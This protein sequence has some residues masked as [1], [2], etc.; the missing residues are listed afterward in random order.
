MKR[1][2]W[3][4]PMLCL[5]VSCGG[6][7][8][9]TESHSASQPQT[10]EQSQTTIPE[11]SD[12]EVSVPDTSINAEETMKLLKDSPFKNDMNCNEDIG[13]SQ[14]GEVGIDQVRFENETL[15]TIPK[16]ATVYKASEIGLSQ[17]NDNN[18]G[19]LSLF[20]K[21]LVNVPGN[22]V[23]LFEGITYEF[24]SMVDVVGVENLSFLGQE[25][26]V[27]LNTSW[28]T[29]FEA[30]KCKN[31]L[32]S[33]IVFDMKYSPT[34]GGEITAVKEGDS[35]TEVTL[36]VSDEYDL[37]APLYANYKVG[38]CSY[39]EMYY[40]QAN[41]SYVPNPQKNLVYNSPSSA[42][43][44]GVHAVTADPMKKELHITISKKF[45]ASSY[46]TPKVGTMVSFAYTMYENEG[47]HFNDCENTY[48]EHVTLHV[49]GGM[50]FRMMEGKNAYFNHVQVKLKEGS[51]SL[52]TCTADIIHGGGVAGDFKIQNCWLESSHDDAVN[53]K[54][55]YT[56][57]VSINAS[58]REIN[59]SQTQNEL[60]VDFEAG[61]VI[62]IFNPEN[63]GRVD[64][65]TLESVR[66][67]G[68]N[69]ILKLDRRPRNVVV[70]Q[71]CG[72]VT[73]ASH[74]TLDNTLIRNKRNRGILLQGRDSK[75]VNCTF[76]NVMMGS[77]QIL[78]VN[79]QFR[80]AIV[81]ANVQ[82]ANNKFLSN[83]GGDIN[84]FAYGEKGSVPGTIFNID[85]TNNYHHN[86]SGNPVNILACKDVNVVNNLYEFNRSTERAIVTIEQTD[87]IQVLNNVL[88][89]D[90][91]NTM[92]FINSKGG[93]TNLKDENNKR[94]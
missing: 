62:E 43:Q 68:L 59:V 94:I 53:V 12:S 24:A 71:S 21:T 93:V 92:T 74:I 16:D 48:I 40:D 36:K 77:V 30:R 4:L 47:F 55:F 75:I 32:I 5:L 9:E 88:V 63:M 28:G 29:Y 38:P 37:T 23:I 67:S 13:L 10:E 3:I 15:Y 46:Q 85:I 82:L 86:G 60:T 8:S 83:R 80:E 65:F 84:V 66:K 27:W 14:V 89:G 45:F 31:I 1:K 20:L 49:A 22:K 44:V 51:S 69:Y 72:N 35:T 39:M 54:S 76:Q 90:E 33:N 50:G 41:Q 2:L 73:K 11:P 34:I 79:D 81:P 25:G 18:A 42:S 17:D 52:M 64:T 58:A 6:K 57:I 26:T 56:K 19:T 7:T 78:S 87:G 91:Q 70:G 61:D